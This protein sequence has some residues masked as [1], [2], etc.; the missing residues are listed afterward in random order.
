MTKE[1]GQRAYPPKFVSRA[2]LAY[3][4][5]CSVSTVDAYTEQ[6]RLPKPRMIGSM[7][8]WDLDEVCAF[9]AGQNELRLVNGSIIPKSDA[10]VEGLE[11][12][13]SSQSTRVAAAA[14]S[15]GESSRT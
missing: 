11:R 12:A 2:T 10:F 5:D 14:R 6:N 13:A 4:L 9:I 8:R 3:L 1:D 15:R 7:A